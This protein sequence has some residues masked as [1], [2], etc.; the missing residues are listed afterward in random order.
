MY[1]VKN[2]LKFEN[3]MDREISYFNYNSKHYDRYK[4][5]LKLIKLLPVFNLF[6]LEVVWNC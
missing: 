3:E 6:P 2:Y 5:A 4:F 1:V